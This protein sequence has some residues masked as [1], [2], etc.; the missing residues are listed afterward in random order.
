MTTKKPS[1]PV[2]KLT[3]EDVMKNYYY[4]RALLFLLERG[5]KCTIDEALS[6]SMLKSLLELSNKGLVMY[7]LSSRSVELTT[8]GWIIA[9]RV[10]DRRK[11]HYEEMQAKS[12]KQAGEDV[13]P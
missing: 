9:A 13:S 7:G 2:S 5:N 10:A 11:Q 3:I 1:K 12:A 6:R 8:E 4:C